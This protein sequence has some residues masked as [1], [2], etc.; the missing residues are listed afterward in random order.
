MQAILEDLRTGLIDTYEVPAP[1]LRE[2]SILVRTAYS[3]ISAGTERA[4]IETSKKSL[5]G[6]AISRPDLVAQVIDYAH[7]NGIKAA[8]SK[9]KNRLDTLSPMG[10]SCSGRV[11]AVGEGVTEFQ[12]GGRVA[13]AGAGYANHC[14]INCIPHNLAVKVPDSVGLDSACLATI[15]AIAVQG[16]RQSRVVLGETAIVIGVGLVGVLTIQLARAAGCR[17]IAID[18]NEARATGAS[19]FGAELSLTS[20]ALNLPSTIRQFSRYGAD[21]VIITAATKSAEPLELAAELC[22]DRAR[23]VVVG[24][25]GMNISRR[26]MYHKELELVMS[27]SYG[28]GRYD[29]SYEDDGHDY[30]IGYVRW[31]EKR[32]MEAFLDLIASGAINVSALLEEA[33]PISQAERAYAELNV[34]D[35]YTAI[36]NYPEAQA[37]VPKP[38]LQKANGVTHGAKETVRVGCIG[39]GAFAR[40]VMFPNLKAAG[41][42]L[43]AVGS[44]SGTSAEAAR[45]KFGFARAQTPSEII[46]D[47]DLDGVFIATPHRSHAQCVIEA[48]KE[49]RALFVEKPLAVS[50]EQLLSV[51]AAYGESTDR[52]RQPFVMVGFNRRFAPATRQIRDFFS[53]RHEP[54]M[55]HVRVNAG[56]ISGEHWLQQSGQGGR[57]VGELCHFVDWA[58]FIVGSDIK[59]VRASALPDGTR[60]RQDNIAAVVAFGDGSIA[61]L[62][63]LTNGD[64]AVPKEFY[65]IFCEGSVA[66]VEN[67]RT[68]ELA[69]NN[70]IKRT[71]LRQDKGHRTEFEVTVERMRS[72]EDAPIA[73][74]E[75][76]EVTNATFCIVEALSTGSA[77]VVDYA[78]HNYPLEVSTAAV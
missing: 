74:A 70:K 46:A 12:I 1:E 18:Q 42:R 16:L 60:Y 72:G 37:E 11:I 29:P 13:C 51:I 4:K 65:E 54:M 19:K 77:V 17:V 2:G 3:A 41:A 48:I 39:A 31:T 75:I 30:P 7:D 15:G 78:Y 52:G 55:I 43:E 10:Y 9:V 40:D 73:F 25:V 20:S 53:G 28:P 64:S 61:N 76:V 50:R 69:R 35:R 34:A 26:N 33:Y 44:A 68:L 71:K 63:Y 36:I 56:R 58:R 49:G 38:R 57:V 21:A 47:P 32:N 24:D 5:L 59:S 6:K 22:R 66:R 14:E 45:A 27:R 23:I 8:Y 67:F 62:L